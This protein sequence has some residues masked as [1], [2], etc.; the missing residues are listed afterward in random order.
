MRDPGSGRQIEEVEARRI[1]GQ[2]DASSRARA[3]P[4]IDA[5]G[6]DRLVDL[7]QRVLV[8]RCL[9]HLGHVDGR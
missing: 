2:R 9:A 5:C 7:E 3:R 8:A 1:D 4:R 6:E